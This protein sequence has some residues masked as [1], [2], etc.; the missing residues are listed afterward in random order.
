MIGPPEFEYTVLLVFPGFG[1][2]REN[3]ESI[4]ESALE[5][6][7]TFKEEPGFRFA[8]PVGAHLQIVQDIDEARDAMESDE[9]VATIIMHDVPDA[10]VPAVEICSLRSAAG[11]IA[12]ASVTR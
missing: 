3:A 1:S 2:E 4:V 8:P 11:M 5:W 9:S 6:L 10:S 7:N 12:S